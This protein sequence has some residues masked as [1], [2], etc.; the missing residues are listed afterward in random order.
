V[1]VGFLVRMDSAC[2]EEYA[3]EIGS[4]SDHLTKVES[5]TF[6]CLTGLS[7]SYTAALLIALKYGCGRFRL[8]S[9]AARVKSAYGRSN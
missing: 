9:T 4:D 3:T 6:S 1:P 2:P 8:N 7:H 5:T